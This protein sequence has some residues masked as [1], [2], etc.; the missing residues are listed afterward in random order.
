[1]SYKAIVT[2]LKNVRP[3]SNADRVQLATCHGNQVVIGLTSTEGELGIYFPSDGQLSPEFCKANNL[4]RD[5][6]LNSDHE[7][8]GMF[9]TNRRVRAQ[10]FRG[11]ISDGFWVPLSN[12]DFLQSKIAWVEGYEFDELNGIP[13]CSKYIN[14]ATAKIARENQGKKTR[15]AKTSIMFKEHFDTEHFG[16]NIHRFEPEHTIIITEKLHG[17]S[18]RIGN[19]LISRDLNWKEKLAKKLGLK[20][21]ENEWKYMNGTRRVVLEETSGTQFHDPTIRDKAYNLFKD[22]LRKGET[23]FFEIVGS[24]STGAMIMPSVDTTKMGDKEFTKTYGKTM[25]YTYGTEPGESQ[26]YVY[27]MTLT[28]EDGQSI[29]YAWDDVVKRCNEIGVK[30]VPFIAKTTL[31]EIGMAV[32]MKTGTPSFEYNDRDATAEFER[33]VTLYGTGPSTL[34]ARHIKEGV[35]VRIEGGLHNQTFKFKSFEFKVLEGIIKD[36]GVIDAEEAQG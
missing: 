25:S 23:V 30:T 8:T 1:M 11:E 31:T 14:P 36:S 27:R 22:N 21:Q 29:D 24:E 17:T 18:G 15:T 20:I 19:V 13:I 10:K 6:D 26:V 5:S 9:D 33:L 35:C 12:F 7:K 2:S 16:K 34:D 3:H 32:T 28:T 4:Y